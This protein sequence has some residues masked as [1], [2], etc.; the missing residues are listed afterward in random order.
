MNSQDDSTANDTF[1]NRCPKCGKPY[2]YIGDPIGDMS[3]MICQCHVPDQ[4]FPNL[5]SNHGWICP[6][7]G[8]CFAP[9]VTEC[10]YCAGSNYYTA[11]N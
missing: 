5:S 3:T 10:P 4:V 1:S 7:C 8:R 2:Y 9:S 6:K 11:T